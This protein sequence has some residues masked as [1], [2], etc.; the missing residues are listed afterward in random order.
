[1]SAVKCPDGACVFAALCSPKLKKTDRQQTT[2]RGAKQVRHEESVAR[3]VA[4][5]EPD[6]N[7]PE[8][9]YLKTLNYLHSGRGAVTYVRV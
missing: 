4:K 2:V 1:M 9:R 8:P 6:A 7:R 3:C 5:R